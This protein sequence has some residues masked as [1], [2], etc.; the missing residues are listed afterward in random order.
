MI[1]RGAFRCGISDH[2][3]QLQHCRDLADGQCRKRPKYARKLI[4]NIGFLIG[5]NMLPAKLR[6]RRHLWFGDGRLGWRHPV[7][8][9]GREV[10]T[11]GTRLGFLGAVH[12]AG[13]GRGRGHGAADGSRRPYPSPPHAPQ[14]LT[15]GGPASG[16]TDASGDFGSFSVGGPQNGS[17]LGML[18]HVFPLRGLNGAGFRGWRQSAWPFVSHELTIVPC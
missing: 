18:E 16:A 2:A 9:N 6:Y 1:F 12:V 4:N 10:T 3:T 7:S 14:W 8:E 5:V 11:L 15:G 17:H 13:V